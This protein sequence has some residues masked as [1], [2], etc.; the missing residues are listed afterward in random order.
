VLWNGA[1]WHKVAVIRHL[2]MPADTTAV[3]FSP[4]STILAT[5]SPTA[6]WVPATGS[7]IATL[8]TDAWSVAFSPH[9]LTLVT[10]SGNSA[11]LWQPG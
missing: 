11:I 9:G 4:D 10:T 3:S 2:Q 1:T 8:P 5:A 6:L 7:N